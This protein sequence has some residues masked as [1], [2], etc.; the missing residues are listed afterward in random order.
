MSLFE[1][2]ILGLIQGITEFLPISSD[3]HLELAKVLLGLKNA[4]NLTFVVAVHG[5]TV[6]SI[7]VVF[8]SEIL[9][10]LQ[11]F[12]KFKWN[13][14][15]QFIVKIA[16]SM[17]PVL[18]VGIFLKDWV[19]SF[20]TGNMLLTAFGFF[21]SGV[22]L[23]F[24]FFAKP[25]DKE[26]SYVH[27]FIIGI[28]QAFAVLPGLSRSGSTISTGMMLGNKK[29]ELARFSFLMAIIPIL[30]AN[31]LDAMDGSFSQSASLIGKLPLIVGFITAFITGLI[32]CKWMISLIKRGKLIWFGVYCFAA[33][34]FSLILYFI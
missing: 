16:I 33:A 13:E 6:L 15:M 7:I 28:A 3:G 30:G 20:F 26:I 2:F 1:A 4:E 9:K 19:E 21:A 29:E 24:G 22:F 17:V 12:F 10:L 23:T 32:A 25:K 27:S 8:F 11:G 34:V 5:A 14:E 18:I 31:L